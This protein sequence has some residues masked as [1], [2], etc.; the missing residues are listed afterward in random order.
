MRSKATV[1]ALLALA[2]AV[3]NGV[4]ASV[5]AQERPFGT[6]RQQAERQQAWLAKRLETVLP[7]LMRSY[8]IDMW[9]IPMQEYNEDP[10][11]TS[12]VAPT[13]FAARR[14]TIYVF[15]DRGPERG[16]E[17]IALGG[18]SQGGLYEAVRSTRAVAGAIAG[19]QAELWGDQQ[20]LVLKDVIEARQP[21]TIGINT[22]RT[23]AFAD[24]LS[25]GELAGMSEA[26]GP[27][28]TSRFRPAEGLAVDFIAS[29]LP[30]EE[31][32]FREL[33]TLVWSMVEE[34]FSSRTITP[35]VTR[36]SDLVWWWGQRAVDL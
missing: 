20:W 34:M 25:S 26:L 18:T 17:R 5:Q 8:G 23:F 19:A 13:T 12:L 4:D 33:T 2:M 30:E 3:S 16:V 9:V 24:G 10:V 35:G 7:S 28:W 32:F 36:T 29:R 1:V 21:K 27:E 14:R 6:V 31:V 15:F 11:F 22:S